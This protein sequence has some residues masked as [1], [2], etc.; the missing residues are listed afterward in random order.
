MIDA[1]KNQLGLV[2]LLEIRLPPLIHFL[3]VSL[4]WGERALSLVFFG[5]LACRRNGVKYL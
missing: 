1:F 5:I 3:E 2:P 4:L